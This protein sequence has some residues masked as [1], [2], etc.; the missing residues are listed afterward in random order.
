MNISGTVNIEIMVTLSDEWAVCPLFAI[1]FSGTW[2]QYAV[3]AMCS[4]NDKDLSEVLAE[5]QDWGE[6][7]MESLED[8]RQLIDSQINAVVS[9][10]PWN[11]S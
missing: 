5:A 11:Y 8:Q 2:D 1:P 6:P 10:N 9:E 4:L 3:V 7:V